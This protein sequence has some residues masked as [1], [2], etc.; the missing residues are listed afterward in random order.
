[1]AEFENGDAQRLFAVSS[2]VQTSAMPAA[3]F[4]PLRNY[5][6]AS[7]SLSPEAAPAPAVPFPPASV[8][9]WPPKFKRSPLGTKRFFVASQ[10]PPGPVE[11]GNKLSNLPLKTPARPW[12]CEDEQ[13]FLK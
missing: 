11:T 2:S 7:S 10:N 4:L 13:K 1:V 6:A 5:P 3:D 9:V 12:V 8:A